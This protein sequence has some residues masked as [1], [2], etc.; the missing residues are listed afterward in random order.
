MNVE[1][2]Q[3]KNL[4]NRIVSFVKQAPPDILIRVALALKVKI[5]NELIE[6]Y[7]KNKSQTP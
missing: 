4:R 6:K 1:Q 2:R 3:L 7:S 5:P